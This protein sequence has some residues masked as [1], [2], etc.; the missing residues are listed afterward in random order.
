M[1]VKL[2]LKRASLN[3]PVASVKASR[4]GIL[5]SRYLASFAGSAFSGR[6]AKT[7]KVRVTPRGPTKLLRGAFIIPRLRG[8]GAVGIAYRRK[9]PGPSG[10]K[11]TELHGPSV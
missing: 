6:K 5:L 3:Y 8:S 9:T 2:K 11:L 1:R 7:V 10:V 4:R